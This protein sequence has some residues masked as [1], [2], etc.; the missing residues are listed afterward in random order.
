MTG[1]RQ[2]GTEHRTGAARPQWSAVLRAIREARSVTQDGWAARLGVSRRTV[3]RWEQ[4]EWVPDTGVEAAIAAYCSEKALLRP[5]QHGPLRGLRLTPELLRDLL[6][7][8]RLAASGRRSP[9]GD[10]DM[11]V[12]APSPVLD[13]GLPSNLPAPLTSF[14]GRQRELATLRRVM[15]ST[16][17]LTLTGVGG[18]G[19]TRLALELAGELL[20]A[21]PHG[22]YLVDLAS[23]A[24][25]SL[26]PQTVATAFGVPN[27]E[28]QPP[29]TV[30]RDVLRRRHLLL[31]LDNCEHLLGACAVLVETLLRACPHLE[32]VATSREPLGISGE[33]LWRVPP[34]SLPNQTTDVAA[35]DAV[36]LFVERARQHRPDFSLTQ[37]NE[38]AV[39]EICRHLDGIPLAIELAAAR[40]KA[41]SVEQIAVR[42]ADRFRLLTGGSRTALPRHQTLR[43]ALDWSHDLLTGVERALLRRLSVFAGGW[44]LEAAEIICDDS[45]KGEGQRQ[46]RSSETSPSVLDILTQLVDK[47]LVVAEQP[48]GAVRYRLLETVRQYAAEQLDDV[49]ESG[50]GAA[51]RRRHLAWCVSQAEGAEAAIRG[52][53]EPAWLARLEQEHDNLRAALAWSLA[54]GQAEPV[55]R[56][57]AALSHFWDLH[58]HLDEGQRWLAVALAAGEGASAALRAK[59]EH[60]AGML[61]YT[62]GDFA[63]ARA[64]HE[65]SLRLYRELKVRQGI[66]EAQGW[67]GMIA[68][69]SGEHAAANTL[70]EASLALRRRLGDRPGI[71]VVQDMLGVLR[72][73]EGDYAAA[74]ALFEAS[75]ALQRELENA[76]GI[77]N[78]LE[79]LATVVGEQGDTERQVALLEEALTRY[80][81]LGSKGGVALVLGHLGIAE[82]TRGDHARAIALLQESLTFYRETGNRRGVARLLANQGF[83]ALS[84]REYARAATLSRESLALYRD[85]GDTWAIGRYLPVLAGALF[86]HGQPEPAAR[87]FAAAAALRERLGTPLPPVVQATHDRTVAAVRVALG[88]ET[89]WTEGQAMSPEAAVA[90]ALADTAPA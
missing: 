77:A 87:L 86:A 10:Q 62:R 16:R 68:L 40:V 50:E 66:A 41:L 26:V 23:L 17:L 18:C 47:S 27:T 90:Y 21:Y 57:A 5:F 53:Y 9:A 37:V 20:W 65:Y 43:A 72:L 31:V 75:L 1:I 25:Q 79:N 84:Q 36:Q 24:D 2:T 82:W 11:E 63:A 67:L 8:A 80:R 85:S 69:R 78:T 58:G 7:E 4:G 34:L 71:A 55:L 44:T 15:G 29:I 46:K 33:T 28:G 13:P 49:E 30:L 61:A 60:G 42:L 64:F 45:D 38:S 56:L 19:K 6:A 35:A 22:T 76:D 12:A 48:G 74:Q 59:A 3:Q 52:P 83:L 14:V 32:V 89:A 54:Q 39:A 81:V 51:I 88:D 70:F 73:R